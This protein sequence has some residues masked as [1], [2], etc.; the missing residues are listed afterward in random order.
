[1]TKLA[2]QNLSELEV[3]EMISIV[4]EVCG[5]GDESE[6]GKHFPALA[7]LGERASD[8]LDSLPPSRLKEFH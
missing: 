4:R 7:T 3:K 8:L 6:L 5:L 2:E 1:M